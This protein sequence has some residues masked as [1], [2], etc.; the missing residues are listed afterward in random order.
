MSHYQ[1]LGISESASQEEI[2]QAYRKLA[3][4]Y[5]PDK[6]PDANTKAKFQ[7]IQEAYSVLGDP[8]KK[9]NYDRGRNNQSFQDI[10][11]NLKTN[12]AGDFDSIFGNNFKNVK[13]PDVKV[14]AQ[15][16]IYDIIHGAQ[17]LFDMGYEKIPVNFPKGVK[18][19]MVFRYQNKG[20]WHQLNRTAPR[21]DLIVTV[22]IIPH[23]QFI[24]QGND[25]W[26]ETN[27]RFYDMILGTTVEIDTPTGR[28]AF[29]VPP[30]SGPGKVLRISGKGLPILNST[31][32]G[33]ILVKL[34]T[35][36]HGLNE[37]QIELIH[38]IKEA[39]S[40]AVR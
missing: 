35:T 23:E 21:G 20:Q 3:K 39:E 16:S 25:I 7:Q 2:K 30:A 15:L 14:T 36:F 17:R 24:I 4:E 32:N 29:K 13:G 31:E 6:N 18:D 9:I 37:S 11:N 40:E 12:F 8:N 10:L 26:L 5:H 22:T 27:V 34:N 28:L 33:S 1:T 38:K 19:G